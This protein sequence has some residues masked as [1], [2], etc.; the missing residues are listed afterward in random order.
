MPYPLGSVA[1]FPSVFLA[2]LLGSSLPSPAAPAS[3]WPTLDGSAPLVVGHRGASGSKPEHTLESYREAIAQGADAIEPD[4]VMTKDLVLISRHDLDLAKSTNIA[5]LA[6]F[7]SRKT[8]RIV[9]GIPHEGWFV[10][11]FTWDEIRRLGGVATDAERPRDLDGKAR[12]V[13]FQ[14]IVSLARATAKDGRR[15]LVYPETKHPTFHRDL[16]MAME[17]SVAAILK[18]EGWSGKE[19]PVILQS[20]E[21]GSLRRFRALGVKTRMVQLLDASGNDLRTGALE[22]RAPNHRPFEWTRT[23]DSTKTYAWMA[24]SEGLAWVKTYAD[25]IGPWKRYLIPIRGR[26][27]SAASVVD[28]DGNGKLDDRDGLLQEPTDLVRRAHA[29]G[30]FV[31][32]FTFRNEARR[33]A[34]DHGGDPLDE[35]R[36][37]FEMGI[38][39]VF[40][41]F[42][43]TAIAARDRSKPGSRRVT[44]IPKD[45]LK[46]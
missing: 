17:D 32:P 9:D 22:F 20:F 16:G 39:G 7:A 46:P 43:S 30:L 37:F 5:S 24:T 3:R 42:P 8:V 26:T 14:E 29:A 27:D 41:D 33:L 21:P 34:R 18:R 2:L 31:H 40:S 36:R 19:A 11:D 12:L 35:Y 6:E 44:P 10:C 38:D 15:V 1:R 45:S 23:E 13:T 25:G 28:L 4:L